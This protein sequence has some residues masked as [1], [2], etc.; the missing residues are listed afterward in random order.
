MDVVI[1]FAKTHPRTEQQ[2]PLWQITRQ[3]T[4]NKRLRDLNADI[5]VCIN[6]NFNNIRVF[7]EAIKPG[8]C[9]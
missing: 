5:H 8:I 6:F 1:L 4:L 2:F 9:T 7:S 3:E